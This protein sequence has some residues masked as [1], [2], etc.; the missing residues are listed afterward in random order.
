MRLRR[1]LRES[2]S[3][4]LLAALVLGC[5]D[6]DSGSQGTPRYDGGTSEPVACAAF[7]GLDGI[8]LTDLPLIDTCYYSGDGDA[9]LELYGG[10]VAVVG[11]SETGQIVVNGTP[12]GDA[13]ASNLVALHVQ[14]VD[15]GDVTLILNFCDGTFAAGSA[16]R[17]GFELDLGDGHDL[18][19][20]SGTEDDDDVSLGLDAVL[21][22][23]RPL[24][25]G[26]GVDEWLFT[27]GPGDDAFTAMGSELAG[28]PTQLSV[29]VVGGDDD[30]QLEGGLGNDRLLG[31][32]RVRHAPLRPGGFGR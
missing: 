17:P 10:D 6:G 31:G 20:V 12:C 4:L 23:R 22:N 21:W 25:Q 7:E 11:R 2:L 24:L 1:R 26:D 15:S 19:V 5:G 9:T 16:S 27:L 28:A 14:Q 29:T 13:R 32:G 18:V 30:D 8:D 3:G